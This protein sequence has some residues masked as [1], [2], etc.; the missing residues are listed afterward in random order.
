MKIKLRFLLF[1]ILFLCFYSVNGQNVSLYS[2]FNGR[3]DFV[4]VGNT[5]NIGENNI[6]AGCSD[7]LLTS[8]SAN[9]NL[10][11]SQTI[12]GVYLYW[13]GSG[14][15]DF[16][17]KLN[18]TDIAAERTFTNVSITSG[19]NYF[20]A[21]ANV[22]DLVTTT[23]NGAYTLSELDL[24]ET[25]NTIPGYCNNR[26]NFAGWS[27]V[28]IYEDLSLPLNQIN[29][30]DGLQSIPNTLSITLTS[31]NVINTA[32][33]EIGFIA[34]EGDSNLAVNETLRLNGITLSNPPLNP[35]NNAFNGTNS[36]T[37]T[38]NLHNMDLDVYNIQN[39]I[40]VGN[41]SALIEMTSGQDVVL[42]NCVV[43][44]LNSQ[45]PDATITIDEVD[46]ECNSRKIL[47]D[48]T[49]YNVNSTDVLSGG[50]PIAIYANGIFI[51]YT[52]TLA[53]IAI[54]GSESGQ[55]SLTIPNSIPNNFTL[56]FVVDDTGNGTGI[57]AE[58]NENNNSDSELITLWVSPLFQPLNDLFACVDVIGNVPFDFSNY[59]TSVLVN[60]TDT[61]QF[62]TNYDDA[63]ANTNP[64]LTPNNYIVNSTTITIFIR[65]DNEHCFSITSFDINLILYPD[66]NELD[67]LFTCQVDATSSFDFSGYADLVNVNS[68]DVVSF[69]ESSEDAANNTNPITNTTNYIPNVVPKEIFVRIDNGF[70]NSVISF[71]LDYYAL[72]QFNSLDNLLVCNEGYT[73]GTFDF[74]S[75]ETEVK[76]NP[77]DSVSFYTSLEDAQNETN[78]IVNSSSF[79]AD[80]TPKEIFVR[81]ENENCFTTTSFVLT[82]ENCPPIVYNYVSANNDGY[83]DTF[84]IEGLRNVFLNFELLIYNRWGRLV[85]TGNNNTPDWDGFA[86]KG[87]LLNDASSP[88]STFYYILY[89]NDENYP[90]ALQGYLYFTK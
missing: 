6:T 43:T 11:P 68:T 79:V 18:G 88:K 21:F 34:W 8:S 29:I 54:G 20:S 62:F 81:I 36:F 32:G 5:M 22:T 64:I 86:T 71:F 48:Y 35:A 78:E 55:I 19:L 89:L 49:V 53:P 83:N 33:A 12:S 61:V 73:Q 16:N 70:C 50:V 25:L 15:G 38:A 87:I 63:F 24:S 13:A 1:S 80:S 41:T 40:T 7:L 31:L 85:W 75:Y 17:V 57:V 23:G 74:S 59:A 82:T 66:F 72:P 45:L 9:L 60:P 27:L 28:V 51:Q 65:I 30:Y 90:Q 56:Q 76:T 47:V 46:Q 69:H 77:D 3:Y 14:T 4:F 58:T 84:F 39:N 10:N 2:Q 52:E 42:M 37:N 67:D 44:K 26:T